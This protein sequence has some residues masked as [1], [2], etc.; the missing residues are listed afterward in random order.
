[1]TVLCGEKQY[2]F[3]CFLVFNKNTHALC[4][5]VRPVRIDNRKN[6]SLPVRYNVPRVM[7]LCGRPLRDNP[8]HY[9]LMTKAR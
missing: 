9:L 5:N 4:T 3:F 1:M 2:N 6:A 7:E 8:I